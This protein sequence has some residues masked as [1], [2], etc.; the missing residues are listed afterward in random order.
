VRAAAASY[1]SHGIRVNCVAP[2]L[3]DTPLASPITT[4][5]AAL[6]AS[7]AMH[8]LR[9]I[10]KP[11]EIARV[12]AWLLGA[13]STWITRQTLGIDGGSLAFEAESRDRDRLAGEPG[14]GKRQV[15]V[16]ATP[17]PAA[18]SPAHR[19]TAARETSRTSTRSPPPPAKGANG[20][21]HS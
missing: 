9:R 10:G 21:V 17:G 14:R 6:E 18:A 13:E 15:T 11:E 2:G 1:A 16:P 12:I 20:V 19:L 4:N 7:A 8:P 5:A 3:V